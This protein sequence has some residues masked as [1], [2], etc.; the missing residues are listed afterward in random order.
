MKIRRN[1]ICARAQN[2][3]ESRRKTSGE[4]SGE[5]THGK[6]RTGENGH[7]VEEHTLKELRKTTGK[8]TRTVDK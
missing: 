4:I 8:K 3:D 6:M 5:E 1:R 2:E 7:G